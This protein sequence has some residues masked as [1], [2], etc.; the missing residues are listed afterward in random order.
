MLTPNHL[1]TRAIVASSKDALQNPDLNF[2]NMARVKRI[3]DFVGYKGPFAVLGDCT[4]VSKK[5]SFTNS[6]SG[7]EGGGHVLGTTFPP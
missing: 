5:A 2:E 6:F 3:A 4:K 7:K 1:P